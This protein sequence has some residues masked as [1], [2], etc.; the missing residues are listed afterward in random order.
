[1]SLT[2]LTFTSS[3]GTRA[4]IGS[5]QLDALI[6]EETT[7]DSYATTYPVEDGGTITD[8]VS[9]DAERLSLSGQ[10]TS[11]SVTLFGP[12]G[13]QKL[14]QAKDVLRQIHEARLPVSISTGLDTYEEMV[15]ERCRIGRSNEGDH[16]T[17]DCDFRKIV[18]AELKTEVVPEDKAAPKVK[19]KAGASR[20]SGGKASIQ[21]LSGKGQQDATEY[22]NRALGI[23]GDGISPGVQ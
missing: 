18:K 11:A 16:F 10:V 5:L 3:F 19:G 23:G 4:A 21:D 17:V 13:W 8:H 12:G 7:L 9:S 1:V 14:V 20:T 22:V 6:S 15:M 2:S